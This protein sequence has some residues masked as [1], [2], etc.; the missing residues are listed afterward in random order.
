MRRQ[1]S[2][3]VAL[4][5]IFLVPPTEVSCQSTPGLA[6][7]L[8][9]TFVGITRDDL[10]PT[11]L[12][13]LRDEVTRVITVIAG[14]DE[15]LIT[16][17]RVSDDSDAEL[18]V[19]ALFG[20]SMDMREADAA[21][22]WLDGVS[23]A[24]GG[25]LLS[26]TVSSTVVLVD[27][28]TVTPTT[29]DELDDDTGSGDSGTDVPTDVPTAVPSPQPTATPT[30]ATMAPSDAPA[31]QPP[32]TTP[33]VTVTTTF[34]LAGS[35][36]SDTPAIRF[37]F[38]EDSVTGLS[39]DDIDRMLTELM[40]AVVIGG[41][42]SEDI[43]S[44]DVRPG[45]NVTTFLVVDV[46]LDPLVVGLGS[47][48]RAADVADDLPIRAGPGFGL[49]LSPEVEALIVATATTTHTTITTTTMS[50][51][52]VTT[53][54]TTSSA[55]S[56]TLSSTSTSRTV[57]SVTSSTVT[58]TTV[59]ATTATSTSETITSTTATTVST[60][61]RTV[62]MCTD[63]LGGTFGPCIHPAGFCVDFVPGTTE[64]PGVT[65]ACTDPDATTTLERVQTTDPT[66]APTLQRWHSC[67]SI[68]DGQSTLLECEGGIIESVSF[69]SFGD[70]TIDADTCNA[71]SGSVGDCHAPLTFRVVRTLCEGRD[72][73]LLDSSAGSF[74]TGGD[75]DSVG[76]KSLAVAVVCFGVPT[77]TTPA[78]TTAA[79]TVVVTTTEELGTDDGSGSADLDTTTV[80][81]STSTQNPRTDCRFFDEGSRECLMCTGGKFLLD[82][83]CLDTCPPTSSV[84]G[85][86][87]YIDGCDDFQFN[88]RC[89]SSVIVDCADD[90]FWDCLC[91]VCQ[92]I[93]GCA[94]CELGPS[95]D[96]TCVRCD[97]GKFLYNGTCHDSCVGF[98]DQPNPVDGRCIGDFEAVS[99]DSLL[100]AGTHTESDIVADCDE[101]LVADG[102][103]EVE[104][105]RCE[106]NPLTL[107][108]K[109]FH[110]GACHDDCKSF[111]GKTF[112]VSGR[113]VG[114]PTTVD[115]LTLS[116]SA[117]SHI[118]DCLQCDVFTDTIDTVTCDQCGNGKFAHLGMCHD[119]C[120]VFRGFSREVDG[121]C[122]S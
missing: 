23:L 110:D 76:A 106:D 42:S 74:G 14:V 119:T 24:I 19:T 67:V 79:T 112:E 56:S 64:C 18:T 118:P 21:A 65:L 101:C 114:S 85:E 58:A 108:S 89:V 9:F 73:C 98:A 26:P 78:A 121:R 105:Q 20:G 37:T 69:A 35:I 39:P 96:P 70:P 68:P 113:C 59:T 12:S 94:A 10:T 81:T 4:L 99:C 102:H 1:L 122:T 40:L 104:C 44:T 43:I 25:L 54:T 100:T 90:L 117:V 6:P 30:V 34:P 2:P 5:L 53:S 97:D 49:L 48:R 77:S 16:G 95:P 80:V 57:T 29:T 15:D 17:T 86:R 82:G 41:I 22:V 63:C 13:L 31:T 46:V 92:A 32:T 87:V 47:A 27:V 55:T 111:R 66:T 103:V 8:V 33:A 61:T 60:T 116:D 107:S 45:D 38:T 7:G 93:S 120:A 52:T 62:F 109:F 50:S 83:R 84:S 91:P 11:E 36:D 75:C 3:C 28:T 88:R 71:T 72:V 51:T 115:C